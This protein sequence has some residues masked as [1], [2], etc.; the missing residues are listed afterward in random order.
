MEWLWDQ[1]S[2]RLTLPG[3]DERMYTGGY[4]EVV[5]ILNDL[6]GQGWDVASSTASANWLFWTL[7]RQY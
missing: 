5:A 7:R 2:L 4:N 6:G 1:D 3:G